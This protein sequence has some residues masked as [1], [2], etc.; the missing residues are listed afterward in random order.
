M[1]DDER[2]AAKATERGAEAPEVPKWKFETHTGE[3]LDRLNKQI[4]SLTAWCRF[5]DD[6]D[7]T[8]VPRKR[9]S[10]G[11]EKKPPPPP[12]VWPPA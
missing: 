7:W 6:I 5:L 3:A 12:P 10:P 2:G 11:N 1:P 4:A 9:P 8:Q